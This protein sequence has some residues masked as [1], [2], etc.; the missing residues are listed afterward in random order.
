MYV[1]TQ[2]R[3]TATLLSESNLN[4]DIDLA[5]NIVNMTKI[6]EHYIQRDE[7]RTSTQEQ[8]SLQYS[9]IMRKMKK[10]RKLAYYNFLKNKKI[11]E[12]Y[13]ECYNK[14]DIKVPK[15]LAPKRHPEES[16][17]EYQLRIKHAKQRLKQEI[18]LSQSKRDSY[19]EKIKTIDKK[20]EDI[21]EFMH[22]KYPFKMESL[23]NKWKTEREKEEF[24]SEQ[25]WQANEEKIKSKMPIFK[26]PPDS[27]VRKLHKEN[28]NVFKTM[29]KEIDV[30]E[31]PSEKKKC[32]VDAEDTMSNIRELEHKYIE[33]SEKMMCAEEN[34]EFF[35]K[36]TLERIGQKLDKLEK[37]FGAITGQR[38]YCKTQVDFSLVLTLKVTVVEMVIMKHLELREWTLK[39]TITLKSLYVSRK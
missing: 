35:D 22:A 15:H 12:L 32:E 1:I 14:S 11:A 38:D 21:I 10:K 6:L 19:K 34:N 33:G 4:E 2:I 31:H 25:I 28:R 17:Q 27:G 30:A 3:E 20:I 7:T 9:K 23:R 8:K 13:E 36:S 37:V 29:S 18:E 24:R 26:T 39:P 16:K 5:G